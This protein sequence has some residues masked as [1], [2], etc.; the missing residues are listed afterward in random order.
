M[1]Y[2]T[3]QGKSDHREWMLSGSFKKSLDFQVSGEVGVFEP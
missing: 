2:S 3:N 1:S